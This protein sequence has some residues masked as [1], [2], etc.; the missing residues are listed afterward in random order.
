MLVPELS[1]ELLSVELE[2]VDASDELFLC[3]FF[4][5]VVS[6]VLVSLM[7]VCDPLPVPVAVPVPAVPDVSVDVPDVSVAD[8]EEPLV[9]DELPGD[10]DDPVVSDEPAPAVEPRV[11]DVPRSPDEV[12]EPAVSEPVPVDEV[13][14][15]DVSLVPLVDPDALLPLASLWVPLELV[16]VFPAPALPPPPPCA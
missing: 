6:D 11:S 8:V 12:V 15:P 14:E 7:P 9:S 1:V 16:A 2:E 4:F 10:V 5:V 3:F 13:L